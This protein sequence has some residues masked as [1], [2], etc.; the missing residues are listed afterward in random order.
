[1]S[2]GGGGIMP[3]QPPLLKCSDAQ[4]GWRCSEVGCCGSGLLLY[5][6][7]KDDPHNRVICHPPWFQKVSMQDPNPAM[8]PW[9][10][11]KGWCNFNWLILRL[12]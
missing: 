10:D 5:V 6:R 9:D 12:I 2:G 8:P 4:W 7:S 1:M 3:L 11:H